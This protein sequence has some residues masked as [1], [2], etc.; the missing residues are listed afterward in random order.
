MSVRA[1][2]RNLKIPQ[3]SLN[4]IASG[5]QPGSIEQLLAIA[6]YF[7][8]SVEYLVTGDDSRPPTLADVLTEDVYDGWLKV[9]IERAIPSKR[10]SKGNL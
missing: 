6:K 5:K 10:K 1:L 8:V 4:A 2:S 7:E 3:S 9:K